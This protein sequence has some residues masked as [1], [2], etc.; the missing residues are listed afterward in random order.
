[1]KKILM[2]CVAAATVA[3]TPKPNYT[4]TGKL[5]LEGN[6][7]YLLDNERNAVDSA[8]MIDGTFIMEGY[9]ETPGIYSLSDTPDGSNF[10]A[11]LFVEAGDIAVASDEENPG[12]IIATGSVSN[13]ALLNYNAA[14]KA[15]IEEYY[16]EETS[17]ERRAAIEA[18]YENMGAEAL[19]ANRDNMFGLQMLRQSVYELSGEEILAELDAFAEPLKQTQMAA[20]LR[21]LGERKAKVAVGCNYI[22]IDQPTP[23][24]EMLSLKSTV[25]NPANRYVLL[26]FWASWCGP[27]MGEVPF[28]KAAYDAYHDKGFEIYAVSF[29]RDAD[30]WKG[31]IEAKE[32]NWIHVS[33]VEYFDNPAAE[34]YAVQAIPTNFLIDCSNGQIVASNLHG[35][36]VS[37]KL[38]ELLGE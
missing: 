32:M 37:E 9:V 16:K 26:D 10:T 36:E 34:P 6:T 15:L 21:D 28:L 12:A 23:A 3:C 1:M 24:G 5:G 19:K 2:L 13:D 18:E 38:A 11:R 17:E 27:C 20:D 35:D 31:A 7:I 25:E 8:A 30:R 29:D 14:A 33:T 22:D 4:I